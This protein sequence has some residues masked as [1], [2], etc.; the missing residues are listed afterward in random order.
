MK[1]SIDQ[2]QQLSDAMLEFHVSQAV[3]K[4][5][6]RGSGDFDAALVETND[7]GAL[8]P[9]ATAG[10]YVTGPQTS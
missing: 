5:E 8:G 9:L 6:P 4:I 7:R 3:A 10:A 1:Q 2:W